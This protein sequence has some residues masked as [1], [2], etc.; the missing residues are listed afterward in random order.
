MFSHCKLPSGLPMS[1]SVTSTSRARPVTAT[2]R[3]CRARGLLAPVANGSYILG[4]RIIELDRQIRMCDPLYTAGGQPMERLAAKSGHS[5]LL[6]MLFSDSVMCVREERHKDAT[7]GLFSRGQRRSLFAG[8]A[9]KV[10]LAYLPAHQ[11]RS[12]FARHRKRIAAAGLGADWES[13]R[14]TLREIREDGYCI[15]FGEFNP[16]VV[17][18]SAPVFNRAGHVLGSLGIAF[19]GAKADRSKF[20]SLAKAVMNAADEATERIGSGNRGV[21]LPARAVG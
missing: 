15:S 1:L 18:I 6:G 14:M 10:I 12:L 4:P 3:R 17:G 7:E 2:S 11:L 13:F 19:P 16:E 20:M 9:S 21:D 5:A 8:A